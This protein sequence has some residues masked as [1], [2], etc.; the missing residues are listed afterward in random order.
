MREVPLYDGSVVVP[1]C[2]PF[3][4][5]DWILVLALVYFLSPTHIAFSATYVSVFVMSTLR[6]SFYRCPVNL[7]V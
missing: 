3:S 5:S 2:D 6:F 1:K 4:L 7:Q